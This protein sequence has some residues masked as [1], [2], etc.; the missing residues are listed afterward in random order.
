MAEAGTD[1]KVAPPKPP[2]MH[3]EVI[4]KRTV[5]IGQM[6]VA[7][8]MSLQEIYNWNME[9]AQR[10]AGWGYSY[11]MIRE[12]MERARRIG[13]SLLARDYEEALI[14]GIRGWAA[15]K[16]QAI[17]AGDFKVAFACEDRIQ[18]IR[19]S[20]I[21]KLKGPMKPRAK[22]DN[23]IEWGPAHYKVVPDAAPVP[24]DFQ[25]A[26][27]APDPADNPAGPGNP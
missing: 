20:Y 1:S 17:A 10:A 11:R 2:D 23:A 5:M 18:A 25:P 6:M 13:R 7:Q 8:L 19:G 27:A 21:P 3:P 16:R 14:M 12:F 15:L 24:P 26:P 22:E 9:P 4:V